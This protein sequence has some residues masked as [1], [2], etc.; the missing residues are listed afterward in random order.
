MRYAREGTSR[1]ATTVLWRCLP[2]TYS[3]MFAFN[4]A[5]MGFEGLKW[6]KE[7]LDSSHTIVTNVSNSALFARGVCHLRR[8]TTSPAC[9]RP[10]EPSSPRTG[11]PTT[12]FSVPDHPHPHKRRNAD[13]QHTHTNTHL[14]STH[15]RTF[16]TQTGTNTHHQHTRN[17]AQSLISI[18]TVCHHMRVGRVSRRELLR[19]GGPGPDAALLVGSVSPSVLGGGRGTHADVTPMTMYSGRRILIDRVPGAEG[20]PKERFPVRPMIWSDLKEAELYLRTADGMTGAGCGSSRVRRSRTLSRIKTVGGSVTPSVHLAVPDFSSVTSRRRSLA[21]T[22]LEQG[23]WVRGPGGLGADGCHRGAFRCLVDWT[24]SGARAVSPGSHQGTAVSLPTNTARE[25]Q[26]DR[27]PM[28]PVG[29]ESFGHLSCAEGEVASGVFEP[30][31]LRGL[32]CLSLRG[33]GRAVVP[34]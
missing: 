34:L 31:I 32:Q 9:W 23:V 10:C 22:W 4:A 7:V 30:R 24:Q 1:L 14:Q 3:E 18:H 25:Q 33:A 5:V 29:T 20:V 11:A 12:F 8:L 21:T 17:T 13:H 27:N 26:S 16:E 28:T 15:E 19:C 2:T 6:M